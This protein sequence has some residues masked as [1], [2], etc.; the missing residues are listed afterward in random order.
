PTYEVQGYTLHKCSVCGEEYKDNNTAKLVVPT[1]TGLKVAATSAQAVKLTCNKVAGATG[2]VFYRASA[3][4]W[5]RVG[6][7]KTNSFYEG[8]LKSG[9]SYRYAVK[10]YKTVNGNNYYS[11]SYPTLW[12]STNPAKVNLIV[13]SGSNMATLKWGKTTS[14]TGYIAYMKTSANGK[15]TRIATTKKLSYTKKGLVKGRT[16]WFTVK[17]YRTVNG[18]TY[19]GAFVTKSVKIK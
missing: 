15:W 16:Y 11:S 10:A 5:V 1:V 18:K 17:A 2:Y 3:G 9:T 6:V 13:T 12:T 7:S 14:A 19:N 4:K 8:K